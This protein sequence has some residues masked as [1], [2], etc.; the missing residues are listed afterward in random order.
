M[1]FFLIFISVFI[2]LAS[3]PAHA[4]TTMSYE[5]SFKELNFR[6]S[7]R[8]I[9]IQQ[10]LEHIAA[11]KDKLDQG[12]DANQRF[13]LSRALFDKYYDLQIDSALHYAQNMLLIAKS[14]LSYNDEKRMESILCIARTYAYS[15]MYKECEELLK[16][17]MDYSH[18]LSKAIKQ[19]YF[20]VNLELNKGLSDHVNSKVERKVIHEKVA[21]TLDSLILHLDNDSLWQGI[22]LGNRLKISGK[23]D[24]ALKIFFKVFNTLTIENRE[25][26]HVAFYI[27]DIYRLKGDSENQKLYLSISA[28]TDIT[29]GVKEYISLWKL[30]I[31]LYDEGDIE[32]AYRFIEISLQDATYTGAYRWIQQITQVLPKIYEAYNA[33]IIQQRNAISGGFLIITFLLIGILWQ[34]RNLIKNK[35]ELARI[36]NNLKMVNLELNSVSKILHLSNAELQVANSQLM[37]LNDELVSASLLKETYLTK[38]IDLCSDYID[39]LDDYRRG[40]KRLLKTG[41]TDK[42]QKELDSKSF[43]EAEYKKFI[44]NFD[45]TFLKLYPNF[46][47]E[48]NS[49]FP[50]HEKQEVKSSELLSTELRIYALMVLGITDNNK[51][52]RFLRC[53]ITTIYT[54]R[55]KIKNRSF[56]PNSFEDK[57]R[58]FKQEKHPSFT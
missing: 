13:D 21:S 31:I 29:H 55:S 33:K 39:K 5:E 35:K 6:L 43:I 48:F 17:E 3:L 27:G 12:F 44:L 45:E 41:S 14:S 53:S 34:Y 2:F 1:R 38:F 49:L 37:F 36:N 11:L 50:D 51:I 9:Y 16:R 19:L 52:S 24:E 18:S 46:V 22:Y 10:K 56:S 47:A 8:D 40:L 15:G 20:L 54:Y 25:M 32:I 57:I 58:E 23:H 42:I 28:S 4:Q 7:N 26:A 30:G